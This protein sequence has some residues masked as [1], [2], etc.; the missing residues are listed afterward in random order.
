MERGQ[1]RPRSRAITVFD[2]FRPLIVDPTYDSHNLWLVAVCV[3][4]FC[5]LYGTDRA[6]E[7]FAAG[8]RKLTEF[9]DDDGRLTR[10]IPVVRKSIKHA[11]LRHW[12][13]DKQL[14]IPPSTRRDM[15]K[16]GE[17][18]PDRV[19]HSWHDVFDGGGVRAPFDEHEEFDPLNDPI[20]PGDRSKGGDLDNI[21]FAASE[22]QWFAPECR[23][24]AWSQIIETLEVVFSLCRDDLDRE[25]VNCRL[26]GFTAIDDAPVHVSDVARQLGIPKAEVVDRLERLERRYYKYVNRSVPTKRRIQ[27]AIAL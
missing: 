12:Q 22:S 16:R 15:V 14:A 7:Y 21:P 18:P 3:S 9:L 25:I 17:T 19:R 1:L 20:K 6:N 23:F 2:S 27:R 10:P 5:D 8:Q 24:A 26:D 11:I 13:K 4:D